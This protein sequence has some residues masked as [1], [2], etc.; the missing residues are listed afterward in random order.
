MSDLYGSGEEP[1]TNMEIVEFGNLAYGCYEADWEGVS[2]NMVRE[3]IESDGLV[4]QDVRRCLEL[5]R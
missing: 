2:I 5:Q 3:L 4:P 1:L